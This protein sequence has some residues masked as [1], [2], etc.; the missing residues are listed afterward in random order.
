MDDR[1]DTRP[2]IEPYYWDLEGKW[3]DLPI[4]HSKGKPDLIICDPPDFKKTAHVDVEKTISGLS[5]IEY[6]RFLENFFFFLK[7][8][9]KK[10]TRLAFIFTDWRDYQNCPVDKEDREQAIL[11]DAYFKILKKVGWAITHIIQAPLSSGRFNAEMVAEMQEKR[12]LGVV[13]RYVMIL[14]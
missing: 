2:A 11:I 10:K 1:F 7:K 4:I 14:K 8:I 6:L 9:S 13:S 3:D 5:K 12:I